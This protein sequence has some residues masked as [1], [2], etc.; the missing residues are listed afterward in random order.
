MVMPSLK[1][2][3]EAQGGRLWLESEM[4]VGSTFSLVLPV[5][6]RSNEER[7]GERGEDL[8]AQST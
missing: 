5:A 4:G 1:A 7:K 6:N 8:P 2:L 3:T